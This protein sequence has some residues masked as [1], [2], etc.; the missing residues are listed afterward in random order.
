MGSR[1][2]LGALPDHAIET[3]RRA[4][5][6][7]IDGTVEQLRAGVRIA[8]VNP[9]VEKNGGEGAFQEF[10]ASELDSLGCRI[11]CWEPEGLR[12]RPN[13]VGWLPSEERPDGLRAHLI[14][15]SHAD[16]V[17]PGDASAW[18]YPPW[19]AP[20][21]DGT[22][23]GLGAIDAKGCLFTFLGAARA[24][25]RA[26]VRLRRSV[27]I[28]AVVDEE[29]GGAGVLDCVRRG[30]TA[31]AA[32]VGEP[33]S[34]DICPASRGSMGLGLR[35]HGQRAH[36]G[37]GWRGVN[38]IRKAWQYVEALDRLRDELDRTR[39]HPLW[40]P[41]PAGHVW[42]LMAM[43]SDV[44][45][46]S[47]PD[48]CEVQYGVGMIGQERSAEMRQVV[49]A[50]IADVTAADPWLAAHPP[51]I[52]WRSWVFEPAV[53]DAGHPAVAALAAARG[54]LGY[55]PPVLRAFSAGSDSRHLTN[56]GGIPAINFGPGELHLAHSPLEALPV[57]DLRK[58]IEVLALFIVRYC[59]GNI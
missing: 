30:Y 57:A 19:S 58:A 34:L 46:R 2:G 22:V 17:G 8:S 38:A 9:S 7:V 43:H 21:H 40:T 13:V 14:L 55:G 23:C 42:N 28:Q 35:V 11:E 29:S 37:E 27:M 32:I 44:G 25:Q 48:V 1:D 4:V 47:V 12:G 59:G 18:G 49:E 10:I 54:D 33:T 36:P 6:G 39:M 26:G 20:L 3:I 50:V 53:T 24:L 15:N 56:T 52:T 51:E 5:A 41:L 31:T 45:G 16:T